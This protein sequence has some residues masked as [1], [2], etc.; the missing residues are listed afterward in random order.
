MKKNKGENNIINN[1]IKLLI[2]LI[3]III[4]IVVFLFL[5]SATNQ[6][7]NYGRII[8][9]VIQFLSVIYIIYKDQNAA[10]K[11]VWIILLMFLPI[12]GFVA[13]LLWGNNK[14]PKYIKEE[15][16]KNDNKTKKIL[17]QHEEMIDDIKNLDRKKEVKFLLNG[18]SYPIYNNKKIEYLKIGEEY[19][20]RLKEDLKQAKEYILIE[21][22]IISDGKMWD[23]IYKILKEKRK[24]NVK[25]YIIFD[26]LGSLFK[27]PKYLKEQL[28]EANIEYLAFNPLTAFI[29][30]YI[31]YRDHRK[32]V[33][34]DGK[35][36]YTGGIN[37]G[38]EYINLTHRLGHWKDCGVRIEG[39]AIKSL[40]SIFFTLWNMNKKTVNYENYINEIEQTSK[41]QGY[42]IP[43]SDNPHNK[44]NPMQNSYINIINNAQKYVY[45]MTPYLILDSET[46]QALI[47][48]SLSGINIKIITPSIPD[49]KLVNACTKSF[50]GKL[51]EAGIE[52]YEYKPGFIHSKVILSDDEVSIVGTANFDFRSFYLNYECGIWMYNTL[53]ELNIKQDFEETLKQCE[54]IELKVWKK[55]KLDIRIIEAL[56]RL[57]SPLL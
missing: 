27:K 30:S 16:N 48:T 46:E 44:I 18:T 6:L 28:E 39:E 1:I 40:I 41:E 50:Y 13:Y 2:L 12:A 19:Y 7:S 56:L 24:Q 29:R 9:T 47:N 25:I 15:I 42:I 8:F 32:I 36:G 3:G 20:K 23:E 57:I 55:R 45:I 26:A 4:Q 37:I 10:Y 21:Y 51:L 22:F 31:N 53:E 34:I 43:F 14:S 54:K 38:D 5:Y 11:I 17:P 52:I 35:V 49:K 33:V